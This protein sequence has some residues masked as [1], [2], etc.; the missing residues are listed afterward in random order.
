MTEMLPSEPER[1][2]AYR[3]ADF[4]RVRA[5][6]YAR[7]GISLAPS[8]R[9][10]VY[11]RLSRRL[12]ATGYDSFSAYLDALEEAPGAEEWTAFTN[13]LTTNLTAFF[14]EAHH[15]DMLREHLRTQPAGTRIL[16]WCC[17]ASTGEEPYSMAISACEAFGTLTPPVS[18]LATDIDTNVLAVGERGVYPL[19]RV[20]DLSQERLRRFFQRGA[21]SN[22][23]QCRV[24]EPLRRLISF[25]ALNLQDRHWPMRGPF[26]AIFCRNVMIYFDKPTQ[27]RLLRRF[28][29]LLGDDG[30]L[31]T[32]H[33]ETLFGGASTLLQSLGRTAYRKPSERAL[34]TA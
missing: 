1:E 11:S 22:A 32:G 26:A 33:S 23:G 30:L 27:E 14:R 31:F 16:L 4:E 18:I 29:P 21:G 5:L 24:V 12:R 15:F 34:E 17:A 7:A 20:R 10:L 2:F 9:D 25:R 28:V 8:K 19:E 6:I 3:P 13:A